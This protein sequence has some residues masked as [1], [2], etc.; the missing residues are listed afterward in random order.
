MIRILLIPVLVVVFYLHATKFLVGI[1]SFV[2]KQEN[3]RK[4]AI[5]SKNASKISVSNITRLQTFPAR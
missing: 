5:G 1:D 2:P 3:E 4:R